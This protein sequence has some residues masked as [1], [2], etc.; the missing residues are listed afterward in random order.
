MK[1]KSSPGCEGGR[2]CVR[3]H[4]AER[5]TCAKVCPRSHTG[6]IK[7]VQIKGQDDGKDTCTLSRGRGNQLPWKKMNV[8]N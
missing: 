4:I 3:L 5:H 1:C 6:G 7:E 2:L 8:K